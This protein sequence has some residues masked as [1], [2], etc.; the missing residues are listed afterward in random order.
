MMGATSGGGPGPKT[1]LLQWVVF[2]IVF[3][4]VSASIVG[5]TLLGLQLFGE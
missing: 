5:I 4:G 1:T 2:A 3:V